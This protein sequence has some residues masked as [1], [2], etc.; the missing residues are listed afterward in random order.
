MNSAQLGHQVTRSLHH[1]LPCVAP[2]PITTITLPS[3]TTIGSQS[4]VSD[5]E[6]HVAGPRRTHLS[7]AREHLDLRFGQLRKQR[8]IV[9][10]EQW[11]RRGDV[12]S[13]RSSDAASGSWFELGDADA[14]PGQFAGVVGRAASDDRQSRS[15]LGEVV[16]RRG[17]RVLLVGDEVGELSR[18]ERPSS[19]DLVRE[20]CAG[21][22]EQLERGGARRPPHPRRARRHRG[23]RG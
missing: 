8:R 3:S 23:C 22:G 10:V 5:R 21:A 17:Q 1:E 19:V 12:W 2:V 4:T 9:I 16:E 18:L 7:V 6:Q 20:P 14:T 11:R 15:E 13:G